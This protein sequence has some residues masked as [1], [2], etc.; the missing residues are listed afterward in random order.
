[1]TS[2]DIYAI[3]ATK[4]HNPHYLKR[5]VKFVASC[6]SKQ[7][8]ESTYVENHHICPKS[9]DL[10]PE[11]EDWYE[12]PWNKVT[13]TARQHILAHII[14]WKAYPRIAGACTP[15]FYM[16]N[17]QNSKF[18]STSG[19]EVP[20]VLEV[21]YAAQSRENFRNNRLG[22]ATYKD[23]DGSRFFLHRDDP[24]I[25][26]MG[27]V[28]Y[29]QG[30]FVNEETREKIRRSLDPYRTVIMYLNGS[31]ES[32]R[33]LINSPD[34]QKH[35]DECWTLDRTE[36]S[37]IEAKQYTA[38]MSSEAN[39][40]TSAYFYPDTGVLYGRIPKDSPIIGELGLVHIRSEN[41]TRQATENT[42]II[43]KDPEV[44]AKK[45]LAISNLKWCHNPATGERHRLKEL[46]AGWILGRG[47]SNNTSGRITYTDGTRNYMLRPGQTPEPHWVHGMA[48]QKVRA[49]NFTDGANWITLHG[50]DPV[51]GGYY[52]AKKPTSR[53][54]TK[55]SHLVAA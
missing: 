25:V 27:L 19:R 4:P 29:N 32:K 16:F 30:L 44:Q 35:L 49:I 13:L 51:P 48:P 38:R 36:E 24:K 28:G 20:T 46:P 54:N 3:L 22:F 37:Y 40:G 2:E 5:Y 6:A 11:Y 26:E 52:R 9:K 17:V 43:A 18:C 33:V 7:L 34:Y 14:L 47:A 39:M 8:P 45:S 21:R 15:V 50:G 1:M 23:A 12:H 55:Y 31:R 42:L 53:R 41:Q 10:F